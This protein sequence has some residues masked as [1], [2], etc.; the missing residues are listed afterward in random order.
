MVHFFL[1][2]HTKKTDQHSFDDQLH[3]AIP[4]VRKFCGGLYALELVQFSNVRLIL[5]G[6]SSYQKSCERVLYRVSPK[7]FKHQRM[8]QWYGCWRFLAAVVQRHSLPWCKF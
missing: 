3:Q 1:L 6:S 2:F 8:N 7:S 5:F 4:S